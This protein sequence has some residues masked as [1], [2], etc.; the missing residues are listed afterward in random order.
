LQLLAFFLEFD[1]PLNKRKMTFEL[2]AE[3]SDLTLN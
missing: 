1:C 3:L 2:P